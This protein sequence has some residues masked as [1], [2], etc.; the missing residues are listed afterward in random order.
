MTA[1]MVWV[2]LGAYF[3]WWCMHTLIERLGGLHA[4]VFTA[5]EV[6]RLDLHIA[7]SQAELGDAPEPALA[8]R[9]TE[10]VDGRGRYRMR[11]RPALL[12]AKGA[13]SFVLVVVAA[14]L[15]VRPG[16]LA[17]YRDLF[18]DMDPAAMRAPEVQLAAVL[19]LSWY[20]FEIPAQMTYHRLDVPALL[21]HWFTS[22][23]AVAVLGGAHVP[24]AIWYGIVLLGCA[25]PVGL[26][27]AFTFHQGVRR[28]DAVRLANRFV[29]A[30]YLVLLGIGVLGT[31]VI[32]VQGVRHG[33]LGAPGVGLIVLSVAAWVWDDLRLAA[34]LRA[35]S[36]RR[37]E[38][39]DF[40]LL[41]PR[42]SGQRPPAAR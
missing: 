21:H 35:A 10:A 11:T 41:R 37:H 25:F 22:M 33:T 5:D 1:T 18:W 15:L 23:A 42:A 20:L 27:R 13:W 2:L 24:Y 30:G 34:A 29:R 38:L 26:T 19:T 12:Y 17:V 28:P 39:V 14:W 3:C 32:V 16:G 6:E 8:R 4:E 31:G 9:S 7:S 36:L 40:A